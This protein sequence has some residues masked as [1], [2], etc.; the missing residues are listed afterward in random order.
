MEMEKAEM[1]RQEW[2]IRLGSRIIPITAVKAFVEILLLFLVAGFAY[3]VGQNDAQEGAKF[4]A[5]LCDKGYYD[6]ATNS[7]VK[8]FPQATGV[9]VVWKCETANKTGTTSGV[10]YL[11][12]RNITGT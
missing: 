5:Y 7:F 8:C 4:A 2:V 6:V 9:R 1:I 11:N 12:T 10:S 3:N